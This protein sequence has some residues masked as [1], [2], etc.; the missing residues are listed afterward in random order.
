MAT[1]PIFRHLPAPVLTRIG[2]AVQHTHLAAGTP[3]YQAGSPAAAL[4]IIHQGQVKIARIS[5][6]GREQIVRV[7]GP[8]EFDGDHALFVAETHTAAAVAMASVS[9]CVLYKQDFQQLLAKEP[10]VSL[11]VIQALTKR[12]DALEQQATLAT[13][14]VDARLATFLLNQGTERFHLPM[15]KKELAQYLGTT[16][17]T[18]SRKLKAFAAQGWLSQPQPSVIQILDRPALVAIQAALT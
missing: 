4:Y 8:G 2:A 9:A 11:A 5:A 1:V 13:A 17:E 3:L 6:D 7:L 10:A 15:K 14:P 18:V 16:P 12:I